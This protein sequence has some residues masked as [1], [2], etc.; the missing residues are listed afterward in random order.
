MTEMGK[1]GSM[2]GEQKRSY[3]Y[4]YT[5]TKLETADTA[6]ASLRATALLSNSTR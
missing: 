6:K 5:G 1:S 3:G 4:A 2:S